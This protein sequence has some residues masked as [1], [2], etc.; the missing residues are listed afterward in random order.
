MLRIS[1][2]S[3]GKCE[4]SSFHPVF[5]PCNDGSGLYRLSSTNPG[6]FYFNVLKYGHAGSPVIV[7]ISLPLDQANDVWYDSP[8]FILHHTYIGSKSEADIHVYEARAS[9]RQ[10]RGTL[11]KFPNIPTLFFSG[12]IFETHF[13]FKARIICANYKWKHIYL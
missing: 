6:S 9:T 11:D 1:D 2:T 8:N 5:T 3:D 13:S 12:F 4:L 7:E 10:I